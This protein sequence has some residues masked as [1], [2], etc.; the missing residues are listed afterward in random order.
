MSKEIKAMAEVEKA[1]IL[2]DKNHDG[3]MEEAEIAK[4]FK[5]SA[6]SDVS[7]DDHQIGTL[8]GHL[9]KNM[10]GNI[11]RKE[12]IS[13]VASIIKKDTTLTGHFRKRNCICKL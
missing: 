7:L 10:V 3:I 1:F 13:F 5:D 8:V 12:L 2:Y 6:F 11:T 4:Y 9:D